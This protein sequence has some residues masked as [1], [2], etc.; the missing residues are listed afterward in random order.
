MR[1][2]DFELLS[3]PY[4]VLL[5]TP[6]S[7]TT[8]DVGEMM[9]GRYRI[10]KRTSVAM[11]AS[12]TRR[13]VPCSRTPIALRRPLSDG[14]DVMSQALHSRNKVYPALD[15]GPVLRRSVTRSL[16]R[17]QGDAFRR[18][19]AQEAAVPTDAHRPPY[20]CMVA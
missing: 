2:D 11:C 17:S 15:D 20:R 14:I 12:V 7:H 10:A 13:E 19:E 16:A 6:S 5:F 4:F 18:H 1:K 9:H 3:S 8:P